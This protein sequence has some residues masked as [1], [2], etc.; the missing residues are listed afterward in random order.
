MAS[1]EE[2][3]KKKKLGDQLRERF[4]Y[5]QAHYPGFK[6]ETV[7]T[8]VNIIRTSDMLWRAISKRLRPHGL[9]PP[10]MGILFLLDSQ[11]EPIP[12]SSVSAQMV[13]T[14][15][16]IT[17]LIDTLEKSSLAQRIPHP[18]DRRITQV[19]I[20]PAGR[21][22]VRTFWPK[23][24]DLL[25]EIYG[26]V[27]RE[28][29]KTLLAVL[30][31]MRIN[32]L[33]FLGSLLLSLVGLLPTASAENTPAQSPSVLTVADAVATALKNSPALEAARAAHSSALA[34][35][36]TLLGV[37]D[38]SLTAAVSHL[39]AKTPP[40]VFFQTPRTETDAGST[41]LS[42][43]FASAT[44]VRAESSLS[45]ETD[46][47]SS[48]FTLNPRI[49]SKFDLSLTQ[50]LLKG[51]IGRPEQASLREAEFTVRAA[52]A[53]LD[54]AAELHARR[55]S[56]AYWTHWQTLR[57]KSVLSE[58]LEEAREFLTTTKK[59]FKR[60][61]AEKDD[62]LRA[63][64]SLLGKELELLEAEE[65]ILSSR[66][67]LRELM[68]EE[69]LARELENPSV[70]TDTP[71]PADS[72]AMAL[73]FRKDLTALK[74]N[75]ERDQLH[76]SSLKGLGLPT[77][78]FSGSLG[79]SGLKD[80]TDQSL[81]QLDRAGFRTW[82]VGLS[83]SYAFGQRADKGEELSARSATLLAKARTQ[84][85]TLAIKKDV[86][87]A[88]SRLNLAKRRVE[89]TQRLEKKQLE[90]FDISRR[91]YTQARISSQDRLT[92]SNAALAARGSHIRAQADS[93]TALLE[94]KAAE[95]SLL[96][97]LQIPPA[98]YRGRTLR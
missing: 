93:A 96:S 90:A 91:K 13:V 10:A 49:R 70:P 23:I 19:Q 14:Q 30:E 77:L 32:I 73:R 88:I 83:L 21:K 22:K 68:A 85:L 66:E 63:E 29:K 78:D 80:R 52:R 9:T 44:T 33:P 6:V 59:L 95:G 38:T 12:M 56:A 27:T 81:K 36:L 61:E 20:T 76:L 47:V 69:G 71:D 53:E 79:W 98:L 26:D 41:A 54:R 58:S 1:S 2:S 82:S 65:A 89:I 55:V 15:A 4:A 28:E 75:T 97:W 74:I 17:G 64:A 5:M 48:T 72:Y 7:A 31:K 84:E 46:D 86:R 39:D 34:R 43:R 40:A 35:Q 60:F 92:A 50:S 51:F 94:Q 57:N 45:K 8:H 62:L 42:K 18:Q 37:Y 3:S 16:N 24:M 25:N 11:K 87:T 67:T